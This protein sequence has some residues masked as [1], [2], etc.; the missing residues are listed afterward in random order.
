MKRDLHTNRNITISLSNKNTIFSRNIE[1]GNRTRNQ[2]YSVHKLFAGAE[3]IIVASWLNRLA[4][5]AMAW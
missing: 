2:H 4:E 3:E 1:K 5:K